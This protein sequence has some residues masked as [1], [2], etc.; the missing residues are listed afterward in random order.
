VKRLRGA[1]STVVAVAMLFAPLNPFTLSPFPHFFL[2][3]FHAFTL[4][5]F[6]SAQ[7]PN[8]DPAK[9]LNPGTDSWPSYNGDYTGRR[10]SPLKQIDTKTVKGLSLAWLYP[11]QGGTKATPLFINGVLYFTTPD[12]AYAV[13][14]RTGREIWHF[15]WTSKGGIHIGNRGM[16]ALGDTLYFETP[17]CH[18]VALNM[19]DGQKKWD[20]TICDLELFYYGSV[21][22]VIVKNHVITGVSGDDLDVPGYLEAHDPANGDFQW[23]WHVVPQARDEPGSETWPSLDAMKHGGGMTWQPVTYDPGLNLIYVTTGNPQPVIAHKN[24]AGSNLFTA[25]IVALNADSGKM[26]WYFQ[27][28]PHDTHDWDATQTA[29]LI[30]GEIDGQPRKLIAQASRNGQFF[31]LDRTNGKAIVSSEFVKTNWTLGYD[32]KG[33]PIPNPAKDPQ[34]DGALVSPNQ[35]GAANWPSP[36][37]SPLTGLF[38]VNATRAFSVYY[39]YDP[40]ENPQ[41]WGGTDRGGYSE[42]MLQAIDYKTGKIRWSHRWDSGTHLGILTTAGNVLVTGGSGGLEALDAATGDA[43]WHSRIGTVTNGPITY[44]MDGLQYV[45]CSSNSAIAAFVLNK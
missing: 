14:A 31:V 9:L 1:L 10:F 13:E 32:A 44:E 4:S 5:P 30:D 3:P 28:S 20:R 26:V 33:Q 41:G 8:L 34:L 11:L 39:I 37:F 18:L 42:Q 21:A 12:H 29:V 23:R 43:L 38:Y 35:G 40:D 45:I 25:S 19:S 2:S 17:D 16:A 22:P 27:A 36:S 7:S 6:V 15:A 24:R